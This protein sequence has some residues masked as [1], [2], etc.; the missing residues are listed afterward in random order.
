MYLR[1][2]QN[3]FSLYNIFKEGDILI[4]ITD[5]REIIGDSAFLIDDGNTAILYDSG[6]GFTGD[7][8]AHKI[9]EYL[10]GRCL[11]YIFLTHSHYDHALGSANILKV[12]PSA[13]VVAGEYCKTIF[14]KPRAKAVMRELDLKFAKKCG[15]KE[16]EDLT[17]C[18]RVDITVSDGDIIKA[19]NMEFR[20]IALPGHTKC[21]FGF[22]LESEKLLLSSETLGVYDGDENII[23]SFLVGYR[24]TL[25]SI[26][27]AKALNIEKMLIPHFGLLDNAH[28]AYYLNNAK[29]CT[30][31][32]CRDIA[33][34]L[35]YSK[36]KETAVEYFK[37]KF[38]KGKIVDAYPIDA[39]TLNTSI[40][41]DLIEKEILNRLMPPN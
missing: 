30:V 21:S 36:S 23:P 16:Y 15:A 5:M 25:D 4:T 33:Y 13:K 40:M 38:Y 28:T 31:Q 14:T 7:A 3:E 17:D 32:T 20:A 19:G 26:E 24:M 29:K 11:D 12:F 18:L 37:N 39:F 2:V 41:I 22:Y 8:I 1:L 10:L 6:F 35:K 27:K 9:K 34:I